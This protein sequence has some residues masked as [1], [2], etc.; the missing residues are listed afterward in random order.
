VERQRPAGRN[1]AVPAVYR[2]HGK[3]DPELL[4]K[5]VICIDMIRRIDL[6]LLKSFFISL[7]VVS[8]AVGMTIIVINVVEEL[9]DFIDHDVPLVNIAEYYL[10]FGGWV[11]KSFLPMFVLLATLFSVSM[12]ARRNEILALK[13]S[14]V[15]LYRIT[16]PYLITAI[17]LSIG[18]IYYNEFLYPPANKR[19]LEIKEFTIEKRSKQALSRVSNIYRQIRPGYFYTIASFNIERRQGRDFKLY[20]T[21]R[22]RLS[23]IVTAP[24]LHYRN[25]RWVARDGVVRTFDSTGESYSDFEEMT[26]PDIADTPEDFAR[27]IGKPEDMS[28]N[29]LKGYI[30]LMKRT[31]GPYLRETIDLNIKLS[32]PLATIIVVL[33]SIP[34]ASNPRRG[35]I[36]VS[37]AAGAMISLVY[38]VLFR[39]LQS[40]G[41]NEKIPKELAVWGVN[42]LFF[43]IGVAALLKARK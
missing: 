7:V 37:I 24:L 2:G 38:F 33:I 31:G 4:A 34:F 30:D 36:A 18:H 32:Y 39:I 35:G 25:H 3:A 19:R 43:I 23:R 26:L 22:N 10:Y 14:G 17:L 15:S 40:A 5:K 42:G 8:V 41:Y 28:Y 13:T 20:K 29:E 21:N 12:L 16:L 27:R 11:L 1:R 6:Y 9:R